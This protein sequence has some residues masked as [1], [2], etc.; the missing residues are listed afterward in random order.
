MTGDIE[1]DVVWT[2]NCVGCCC[3]C[4][5]TGVGVG[6]GT[7]TGVASTFIDIEVDDSADDDDAVVCFTGNVVNFIVCNIV[8]EV[9]G[10]SL[11]V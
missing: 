3:C 9:F 11:L 7:G 1:D 6:T 5:I 8:L 2:R 10:T 4:G